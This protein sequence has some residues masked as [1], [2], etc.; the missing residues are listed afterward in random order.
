LQLAAISMQGH[1]D[2]ARFINSFSGSHHFVLDYLVEEVLERQ[3]ESVQTFLLQTAVLDRL[4]GSLCDAVTG[5][6]NGQATLELLERANLFIVPLDEERRWYRYHHLFSGLL[7]QRLRQIQPEQVSTLHLQASEW[8]EQNG[9]VDESIEYA[10][11]AQSFERAAYL[12]ESAAEAVWGS[13]EHTKLRRWLDG[14]PIALV[15]SKPQLC[16]FQAGYLFTSGQQDAAERSLQ[17]AEQAL[18]PHNDLATNVSLVKQDHLAET[19]RTKLL[20]RIAATRSFMASYRSDAP[21]VIPHARQ[22]LAYLPEQEITWRGAA[23]MALGDAYIYQGQYTEAHHTYLE[24]LEAIGATGNTY[25]FMNVS[26]KLALNLRSQ[27]RLRQVIEICQQQMEFAGKNGMSQTEMAGWLLAIWGEVLAE[28]NDLDGAIHQ[29]RKGVELTE[30]GRDVAMRT[31][32]YLCLTRVLFSRGDMA[33]AEEIIRASENIA[34]EFVVPLWITNLMAAWQVRVWLAQDRLDKTDQWIQKRRLDPDV[35]PTYVGALEYIALARVLI[36]QERYDDAITLLQRLLKPAEAGAHTTRIIEL[37]ILQGLLFQARGDK[38]QAITTL[39]KALTLAEPE[40]FIRIF[41]DE[42]PS[43]ARLLHE[44][45]TRKISPDYARRLLAAFSTTEP[46]R[47][48][49]SETKVS[50]SELVE[51]LSEREIEVLQLIA[52]GL[53]NQEIAARLFLSLNTV[54]VHTRNIYG[55]LGVNNRTQAV[56]KARALGVLPS[57]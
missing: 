15:F 30:R 45:A 5:Q 22:A 33:G 31:W 32:G 28:L 40:G 56:S 54:K 27:G 37:L 34:R 23:A 51:P 39:E 46:E 36:A 4:T 13:G 44:A 24:A 2:A 43:I 16:V 20:G 9:L 55:K 49:P 10:L 11:Q 26:L 17:I 29:V 48:S 14:L 18:V 50:S 52:E 3:S 19:D 53:T 47:T 57:I 42:G 6:D 1:P 21:G 38:D 12:I 41:V 25:I 35:Q 7:R 8:Y